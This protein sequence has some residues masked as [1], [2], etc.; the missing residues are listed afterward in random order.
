[1]QVS[2]GFLG[3]ALGTLVH[4]GKLG[5]LQA[6]EEPVLL[7]RIG[8][9]LGSMVVL[10]ELDAMFETPVV[11]K[12]SDSCMLVKV[13]LLTVVRVQFVPVS[14]G[15][16]HEA[17]NFVLIGSYKLIHNLLRYSLYLRRFSNLCLGL[18][19]F[20]AAAVNLL[21]GLILTMAAF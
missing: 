7:H 19:G 14:P 20:I 6:V 15:H 2:E 16:Q 1:M 3:C 5:L 21:C 12:P 18:S 13:R 17:Q 4:P 8:E 10:E 11:G 9:P